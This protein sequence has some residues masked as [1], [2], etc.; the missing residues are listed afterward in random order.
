MAMSVI[1]TLMA[2]MAVPMLVSICGGR[3]GHHHHYSITVALQR[4]VYSHMTFPHDQK[5]QQCQCKGSHHNHDVR[6]HTRTDG[7]VVETQSLQD[8][9]AR[10]LAALE[11]SVT[12]EGGTAELVDAQG[13]ECPLDV[14]DVLDYLSWAREMGVRE[15]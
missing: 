5:S 11:A 14:T 1:L 12:L 3:W 2:A 4:R 7:R 8:H 10:G 15:V 9:L 13:L 6:P